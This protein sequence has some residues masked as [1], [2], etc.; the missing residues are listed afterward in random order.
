MSNNKLNCDTEIQ[1][2]Q[3]LID[4]QQRR[5]NIYKNT[6]DLTEQNAQKVNK[7]IDKANASVFVDLV[8]IVIIIKNRIDYLKYIKINRKIKKLLLNN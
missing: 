1:G 8:V 6:Q 7:L 2:L 3:D 5:I 4:K